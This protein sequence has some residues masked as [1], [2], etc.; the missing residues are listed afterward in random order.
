VADLVVEEDV[1]LKTV[2]YVVRRTLTRYGAGNVELD[3]AGRLVGDRE[4]ADPGATN[5]TTGRRNN[6]RT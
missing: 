1:G 3:R 6:E 4:A 5:T 2:S